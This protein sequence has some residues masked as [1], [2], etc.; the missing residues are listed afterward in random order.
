MEESLNDIYYNLEDFTREIGGFIENINLDPLRIE[1][2]ESRLAE[3]SSLCRKYGPSLEAVIEYKNKAQNQLDEL[4]E[5]ELTGSQYQEEYEKE[6]AVYHEL[7]SA[8]S[9][10]RE[11]ASYKLGQAITEEL[12]QLYMANASLEIF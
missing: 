5:M 12:R 9:L 8:L 3:L 4:M 6:L 11:S 7:A 1:E 2:V 10:L